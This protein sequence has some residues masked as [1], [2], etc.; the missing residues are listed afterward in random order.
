[1]LNAISIDIHDNDDICFI[2]LDNFSNSN[3]HKNS[4]KVN[5]CKNYIHEDC[6]I[7]LFVCQYINCPLCRKT[8]LI[9]DYYNQDTFNSIVKTFP[10]TYIKKNNYKITKILYTLEPTKY[11]CCGYKFKSIK[12]TIHLYL[13]YAFQCKKYENILL[14]LVIWF[15]SLLLFNFLGYLESR[16]YIS[17]H[18]SS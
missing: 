2:C 6:L 12:R 8:I 4:I 10:K 16:I 15:I 3:D 9:N 11:T 13:S 17:K 7:E 18:E 1:M 14:L 5:C